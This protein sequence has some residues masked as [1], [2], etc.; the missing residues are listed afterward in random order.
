MDFC[1]CRDEG[2]LDGDVHADWILMRFD[3]LLST[4]AQ[5]PSS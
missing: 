2:A 3:D 1:E 5:V 4:D